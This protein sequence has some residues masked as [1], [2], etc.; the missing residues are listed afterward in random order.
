MK[1][2][3]LIDIDSDRQQKVILGKPN[4]IKPPTNFEEAQLLVN[5]DVV[6]V[7]EAL[8][9]LIDLADQNGYSKREVMVT[10]AI[11]NLTD[12]LKPKDEVD[13]ESVKEEEK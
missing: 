12:L 7:C 8:C 4:E 2:L 5:T 6:C 11:K 9:A 3:L 1:T 13:N 10:E